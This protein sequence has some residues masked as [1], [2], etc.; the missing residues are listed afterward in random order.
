MTPRVDQLSTVDNHNDT[1]NAKLVSTLDTTMSGKAPKNY[2][3]DPYNKP[4]QSKTGG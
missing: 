4:D 1:S 3:D 2:V